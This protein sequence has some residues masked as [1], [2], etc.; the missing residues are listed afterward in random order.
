[1]IS[2]SSPSNSVAPTRGLA[3]AD[4]LLMVRD[5]L[6]QPITPGMTMTDFQHATDVSD[7]FAHAGIEDPATHAERLIPL[8]RAAIADDGMELARPICWRF[9]M[10]SPLSRWRMVWMR[11]SGRWERLPRV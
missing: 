9:P 7:L 8:W 1:M 5:V 6:I 10:D 2:S 4:V 3:Q 11:S